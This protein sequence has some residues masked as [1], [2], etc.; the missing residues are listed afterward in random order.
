MHRTA[1]VRS[2]TL[3]GVAALA[4]AAMACAARAGDAQFTLR[5]SSWGSPTAPQV[6]VFVPAFKTAVEDGS[7]GRIAV[8]AFPA[9][10]LVKEQDV[11]SAIQSRVVDISLSTIGGWA[12]I[13]PPAALMNSVMF[14]PTKTNFLQLVGSG[15]PLFKALDESLA[16]RHVHLLAVLDNG[17]PMLVTRFPVQNPGDV[18]GKPIRAYDK[19]SSQLIQ[20]FGGA[21]STMS[22][23]EVYPA[24]QHGIVQGAVGGIQGAIG[25][26]EYEVAKYLLNG[27]GVWGVGVTIYV[28]NGA[29]L[30]ALPADL[31]KVV[32]DAGTG[33]ELKTNQAIFAFIDK[34]M[35]EMADRGMTV[36]ELQPGTGQYA[37]FADALVPL[38]KTQLQGVP[39]GLL[40]LVQDAQ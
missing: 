37:A 36:T 8:Q 7:G 38:A 35:K 12:S 33:A 32:L 16:K 20:T 31:Q 19:A 3:A 15:S 30:S 10:A 14:R 26:K 5:L 25:L 22:V 11:P 27:N 21:P 18:R 23:S 24:L 34:S 2:C 39:A 40:K 6:S 17:P 29:A 4:L 1:S 9:G 13:S 28:M